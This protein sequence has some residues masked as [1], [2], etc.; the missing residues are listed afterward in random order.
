MY[1][2]THKHTR[3]SIFAIM[4]T[5]VDA[6]HSAQG[7]GGDALRVCSA[8]F[9]PASLL[10][11]LSPFTH[12]QTHTHSLSPSLSVCLPVSF[13][14]PSLFL[15]SFLFLSLSYC[16]VVRDVTYTALVDEGILFKVHFAVML[17]PPQS[18]C[19]V[20]VFVA[21]ITQSGTLIS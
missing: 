2:Y 8:F 20:R 3:A 11:T 16:Q 14:I 15:S 21:R 13:F 10:Y 19:H 1:T 17:D 4:L 12:T 9:V 5:I 7:C 6:I 18:H